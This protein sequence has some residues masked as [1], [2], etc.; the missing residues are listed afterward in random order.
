[1]SS[2]RVNSNLPAMTA[3]RY[4]GRTNDRL[5]QSMQRLSTG[6][7]IN[8]AG[9]DPAGLIASETFRSQIAGISQAIRNNQD[10]INFVKTAEAALDEISGLLKDGRSLAVSS[11]N[12]ATLSPSQ[13]QANQQQWDLIT[14]SIDRISKQT[15]FGSKRLLDGSAGITAAIEDQS[16]IDQMVF[17]GY[18]SDGTNS[19]AI[20]QANPITVEVTT[21]A[22]KAGI[23]GN[24]QT[25]IADI[26]T[27][28][29]TAVPA[30]K[31]GTFVINGKSFQIYD[32]DTYGDVMQRVNA[33][34]DLTGVTM[35]AADDGTDVTLDLVASEIGTKGDFTLTDGVGLIHNAGTIDTSTGT[36]STAGVDAVATVGIGSDTVTMTG[37]KMGADGLTLQDSAGNRIVLKTAGNAVAAGY[38][39]GQIHFGDA[40]FQIGGNAGQRVSF[41][42]GDFSASGIGVDN[43]D[44]T[45]ATGAQNMIQVLE[46][47]IDEFSRRR[48]DIGAFQRN[49][50][51]SNVRSLTV[52]KESLVGTES[53]IRDTDI[54]EEMTTFTSMQILQQAGLSVL[55]QANSMPQ[56][57][58]SLLQ[59]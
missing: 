26:D 56:S 51:E 1:M 31:L 35:K 33:A 58:L 9:D 52:A 19:F 41:S 43:L 7:R 4:L 40:Q 57:V 5:G 24:V 15:Q 23:T 48:G 13:L 34:A 3:H 53:Q 42:L 8:S 17:G 29:A 20:N 32:G 44:M 46:D 38:A 25:T 59:G 30:D 39:A 18:V 36:N 2:F 11:A 16:K 54:S 10:A 37:G 21:A 27:F 47:K 50:L 49:V 6:F 14:N 28:M 45:T 12:T 22:V 55:S